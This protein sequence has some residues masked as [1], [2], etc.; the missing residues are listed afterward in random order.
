MYFAGSGEFLRGSVFVPASRLLLPDEDQH[1]EAAEHRARRV[2][3]PGTCCCLE[4]SQEKVRYTSYYSFNLVIC[5]QNQPPSLSTL[6]S[7]L[8]YLRVFQNHGVGCFLFFF[9]LKL[10]LFSLEPLEM[11]DAK[12]SFLAFSFDALFKLLVFIKN[13]ENLSFI[14]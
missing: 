12:L 9:L 10:N 1:Q 8:A 3:L 5:S 13:I 7:V 6:V 2:A 4:V 11:L 14:F